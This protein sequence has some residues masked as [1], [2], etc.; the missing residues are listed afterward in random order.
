MAAEVATSMIH[1]RFTVDDYHHMAEVGILN[2]DDRVELIDGEIV[3]M[4]PAGS[5][6]AGC[7]REFVQIFEVHVGDD[8]IVDSQNPLHIGEYTEPEPDVAVLKPRDDKYKRS[9]PTAKDV[10]LL[11]EVADSSVARDRL[12]K[13]PLYAKVGIAECWLADL[14]GHAI[15]RH[16]DPRD[17]VYNTSVRVGRGGLLES[18]VLPGLVIKVDDILD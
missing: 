14:P 2:E 6:H 15:E 5:L 16:T 1:R 4:S 12:R 7:I 18:T 9:H 13:L 11:V 10:I 3:E 17:G 8:A